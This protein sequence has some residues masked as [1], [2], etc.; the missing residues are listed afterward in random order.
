MTNL[1]RTGYHVSMGYEPRRKSLPNDACHQCFMARK[2]K[3]SKELQSQT[4]KE[5]QSQTSKE[6]QTKASKEIA[7]EAL[8]ELNIG[9]ESQSLENNYCPERY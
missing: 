8:L 1:T 7:T 6:L 9:T 5:L 2:R 4:S 3:T